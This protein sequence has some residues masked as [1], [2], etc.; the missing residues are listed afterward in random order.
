MNRPESSGGSRGRAARPCT[1]WNALQSRST[2]GLFGKIEQSL[3]AHSA[4]RDAV[5]ARLHAPVLP[6]KWAGTAAAAA[7][8]VTGF[9]C[10][11]ST[12]P[13]GQGGNG[14]SRCTSCPPSPNRPMLSRGSSSRVVAGSPRSVP[15]TAGP[16]DAALDARRPFL[17]RIGPP[18]TTVGM[19]RDESNRS[20]S[21]RAARGR[22]DGCRRSPFL[23][24][25]LLRPPFAELREMARR[26]PQPIR[27]DKR[28]ETR[29][30][31]RVDNRDPSEGEAA[32]GAS[33]YPSVE[34]AELEI[35]AET[36]VV[37]RMVVRRALNGEPFATVTYTLAETDALDPADYQ[38]EGHVADL[39]N[40]HP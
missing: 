30:R 20:G 7:L 13:A 11:A 23:D 34:N 12:G 32:E 26:S 17:G 14:R 21:G 31:G 6:W 40:L 36:R 37:R 39:G 9:F 15:P 10:S 35:D 3:A 1:T 4:A 2:P 25:G 18:R 5:T 16:A 27:A 8:V 28:D 29:R 33:Q 22:A 38:L 24:E 19:G